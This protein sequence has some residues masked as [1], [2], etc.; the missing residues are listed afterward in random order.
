MTVI[1]DDPFDLD[2]TRRRR[3]T[4]ADRELA[5]WCREEMARRG[6]GRP[7]DEDEDEASSLLTHLAEFDRWERMSDT[8]RGR[9][10]GDAV[11]RA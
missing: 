8:E 6:Q 1:H 11:R 5:G 7:T 9:E 3:A 2:D 10:I 4:P